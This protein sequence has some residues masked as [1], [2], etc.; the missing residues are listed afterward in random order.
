MIRI[1]AWTKW[2]GPAVYQIVRKRVKGARHLPVVLNYVAVATNF[3]DKTGNFERF[4]ALVGGGIL[5]R[6]Y[7]TMVFGHMAREDASTDILRCGPDQFGHLVLSDR[8]ISTPPR[9]GRKV[10][11]ALIL[12]GIAEEIE[13]AKEAKSGR[14]PSPPD[15]R[16]D[17]PPSGLPSGRGRLDCIGLDSPLSPLSGGTSQPSE[18]EPQDDPDADSDEP[19]P[20]GRPLRPRARERFA[21]MLDFA[22]THPASNLELPGDLAL[23]RK[24]AAGEMTD[25]EIRAAMDGRLKWVT[26]AKLARKATWTTDDRE[27]EPEAP[28][29]APTPASTPK[30]MHP[31][32]AA[33]NILDPCGP[34]R[35][36]AAAAEAERKRAEGKSVLPP[37]AAE[38]IRRGLNLTGRGKP[39]DQPA[40]QPKPEP[41][42]GDAETRK[43]IRDAL[44]NPPPS[45]GNDPPGDDRPSV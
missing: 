19:G 15:S 12:S 39:T 11:E 16:P 8:S 14:E 21:K 34:C 30:P 28:K 17:S 33:H 5:A 10:Y 2:Q 32:C 18:P 40:T 13:P 31:R 36:A 45:P 23:R 1:R 22:C 37:S 42:P 20:T 3:D 7:L 25:D 41:P 26:K 9:V 24:F 43:R 35:N 27:G 4:A 6:G 29:P 44:G 38:V